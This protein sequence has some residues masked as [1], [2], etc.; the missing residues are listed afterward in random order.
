[1]YLIL[2]ILIVLVFIYKYLN[3]QHW[4]ICIY[5]IYAYIFYV[6]SLK[7]CPELG[8]CPGISTFTLLVCS[9][10]VLEFFSTYAHTYEKLNLFIIIL[11]KLYLKR[12][13]YNFSGP[14]TRQPGS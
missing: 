4:N 10:L 1:M 6:K 8:T 5:S 9:L 7:D 2:G 14:I 13:K 3:L 12:K 11:K